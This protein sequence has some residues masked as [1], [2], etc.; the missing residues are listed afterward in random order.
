MGTINGT[1]AHEFNV[2]SIEDK[3]WRKPGSDI[4]DYFNYG[5]NE[6]TW[7]AYCER[8]KKMRVQESGVGLAG[9]TIVS[10]HSNSSGGYNKMMDG[11]IKIG[12]NHRAGPPPFR[13]P[14]SIDVIGGA[15][16]QMMNRRDNE[17]MMPQHLKP[18]PPKENV[19]QVMTADRREYSRT[20]VGNKFDMPPP[21]NMPPP[22]FNIN[23]EDFYDHE[24][25]ALNYGGGYEPTQDSQWNN[26]AP[27]AWSPGDIKQ[28]TPGEL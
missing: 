26:N 14:G 18:P 23:P 24:A 17:M 7:R 20:V 8:Q 16:G 2:E 4:T 15:G 28:L 13:K 10:A 9:L 11:G 1:I 12:I 5:F 25:E 6:D 19:I 21:M 3:P 27:P 22:S